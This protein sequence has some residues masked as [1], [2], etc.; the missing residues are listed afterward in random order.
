MI[1]LS[2]FADEISPD[3]NEQVAVLLDEN[4]H[5]IDFRSAWNTN[6]LDLSDEQVEKVRHTL[7]THGITIAAIGSPLGKV[8]VDIDFDE[9]FRHFERAITL[10]NFFNTRYIRLFSFY[11]PLSNDAGWPAAYRDEV[12]S[13]L[14]RMTE[15]AAAE[16]LILLHENEK[17]I[18]GDSIA[19]NV[20]LLQSVNDAHL[21]A[22]L[23]P[24]NYLQCEQV[25]YPDAYE[26]VRPWLAYVHVKDVRPDGTLAVAGEGSARWPDLL[27]RL[28]ADGYDGFLALEPHL[29]AAG[30]YQGFSGPQ[31]FRQASQALQRLL[32]DM[33]WEYA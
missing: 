22:V 28:R 9:H 29:A 32:H 17:G 10:A 12:I 13:H 3:L 1:R 23:D 5:S 24:A 16:N 31:L 6:V 21:R 33:N 19:R 2:A 7:D 27:Q 18:Y 15:R 4:I 26:A 20:D 25:P 30:Q 14:R 8:P 11:P